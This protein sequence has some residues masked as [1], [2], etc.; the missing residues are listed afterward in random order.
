ME[1]ALQESRRSYEEEMIK[2]EIEKRKKKEEEKKKSAQN[3][4]NDFT[5][6]LIDS[7]QTFQLDELDKKKD[8]KK[9]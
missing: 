1:R 3:N 4:D 9:K 6:A 8:E 2:Q 7:F 5:R